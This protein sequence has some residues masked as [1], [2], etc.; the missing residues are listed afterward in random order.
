MDNGTTGVTHCHHHFAHTQT[1]SKNKENEDEQLVNVNVFYTV[2]HKWWG[3]SDQD[4]KNRYFKFVKC[5]YI[6]YYNLALPIK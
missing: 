4:R 3:T 5:H 6:F 2:V 1:V